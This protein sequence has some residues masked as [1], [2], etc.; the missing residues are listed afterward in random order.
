M[1]WRKWWNRFVIGVTFLYTFWLLFFVQKFKSQV[2]KGIKKNS[3]DI[4]AWHQEEE[5]C[6]PK[7]T[8]ISPFN[9]TKV[10]MDLII[11]N[12]SMEDLIHTWLYVNRKL[13]FFSTFIFESYSDSI[14]EIGIK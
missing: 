10:N 8:T 11:H 4:A 5:G 14:L 12:E 7:P 1:I 6:P 9:A 13:L 3:D 2:Q